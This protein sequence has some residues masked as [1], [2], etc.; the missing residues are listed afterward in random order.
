MGK[1]HGDLIE[2]DLLL[3]LPVNFPSSVECTAQ[4]T[5]TLVSAIDILENVETEGSVSHEASRNWVIF[6]SRSR[7]PPCPIAKFRPGQSCSL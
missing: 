6:A 4:S 1:F 7:E 2:K 3:A 5:I